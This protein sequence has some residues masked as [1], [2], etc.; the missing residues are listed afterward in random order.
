MT[1]L[2]VQKILNKSDKEV[3]KKYEKYLDEFDK[4]K[5]LALILK[6]RRMEK[7]Y[8]IQ[9]HSCKV[10]CLI[11]SEVGLVHTLQSFVG[12]LEFA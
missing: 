4:M 2:D 8:L 6:N 7:G 3:L 9:S 11:R 5:E 12:L 1:Y 10:V